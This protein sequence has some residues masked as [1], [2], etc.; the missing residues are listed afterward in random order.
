[1]QYL[2]VRYAQ[3]LGGGERAIIYDWAKAKKGK[4]GRWNWG[5]LAYIGRYE[6]SGLLVNGLRVMD[7]ACGAGCGTHYLASNGADG[8][9]G[10]DMSPDAIG[11]ATRRYRAKGLEFVRADCRCLSFKSESFDAA[12]SFDT[13]EHLSSDGQRVF[14]SEIARVL[15]PAGI[16]IIGTPNAEVS[17]TVILQIPNPFHRHELN[18]EEFEGLLYTFFQRVEMWGEDMLVGGERLREKWLNYLGSNEVGMQN[19]TIVGD[20][21]ER[22][23]GLL[24]ICR[25]PRV[26]L[27]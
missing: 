27:S 7:C 18:R 16:A 25:G 11:W 1:M 12:V 23:R 3:V 24:A 26:E 13:L 19:I 15:R 20:D 4:E 5:E 6:W 10:V 14:L 8:A 21:L 9:V 2:S 22:V 17:E